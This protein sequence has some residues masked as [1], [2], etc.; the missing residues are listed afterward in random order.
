MNGSIPIGTKIYLSDKTLIKVE[1]LKIGDEVLSI[2]I[3]DDEIEDLFD[4]YKKYLYSHKEFI[5]SF[6]INFT[7]AKVSNKLLDKTS[8]E[9]VFIND[10]PIGRNKIILVADEKFY[11]GNDKIL[12]YTIAS[13]QKILQKSNNFKIS[14][15]NIDFSTSEDTFFINN[16]INNISL[17]TN[18]TPSFNLS[19]IGG[20]FYF[21][22]NFIIMANSYKEK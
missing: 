12:N 15:I 6:K 17:K 16:H 1:D 13:A 7:K 11:S 4:L 21:T 18:E 22:E 2:K 14:S 8:R 10:V 9:F 3:L 20:D 5:S 19:I